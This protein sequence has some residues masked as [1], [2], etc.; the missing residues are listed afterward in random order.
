MP[1]KKLKRTEAVVVFEANL[2]RSRAFLRIFDADRAAGRPTKDENELLRGAI[3]FA[4]GAFDAYLSDL[5]LEVVPKYGARSTQL[6][7]ALRAIAKNDPG[8]SLRVALAPTDSDRRHEFTEALGDWLSTKT[9]HGPDK[10]DDALGYVACSV[11]WEDLD[12]ACGCDAKADLAKITRQRH[13]IVHEG[14]RPRTTRSQAEA[15]ANLVAALAKHID[16]RVCSHY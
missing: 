5:I 4:V 9:F 8:L 3:V 15:A 7:T 14:K 10:V 16:T 6:A 13:E 12:K 11:A 2:D 1:Q